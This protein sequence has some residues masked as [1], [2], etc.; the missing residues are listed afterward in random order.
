MPEGQRWEE[1]SPLPLPGGVNTHH[2]LVFHGSGPNQSGR[3]RRSLAIH[4]RSEGS[5]PA[6]DDREGLARHIDNLDICP[7]IHGD[8]A[9]FRGVDR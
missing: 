9:L 6:D 3:P 2:H 4:M 5:R 1:V 8:P 7:V